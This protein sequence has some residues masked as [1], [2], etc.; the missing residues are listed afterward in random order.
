MSHFAQIIN[1]IVQQVIVAEQDFIDTLPDKENWIKT[2]YNSRGNEH[3]DPITKEKDT[4]ESKPALRANYASVGGNYDSTNDVFYD[5]KP[6]PSWTLNKSTWIWEA[7]T[8]MP[9][10][11]IHYK[12]DE[13]TKTWVAA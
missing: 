3:F 9:N 1:G 12:W 2:S 10:D 11:G 4:S 6:Y 5:A 7:P 13:I 8:P